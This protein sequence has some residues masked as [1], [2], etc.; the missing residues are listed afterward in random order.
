MHYN[1]RL[2][3]LDALININFVDF[4][5][6]SNCTFDYNFIPYVPGFP[7]LDQISS[8]QESGYVEPG[9]FHIVKPW[10]PCF[11]MAE[12]L[13]SEAET[14]GR[15]N[16][17]SSFLLIDGDWK[18]IIDI[19]HLQPPQEWPLKVNHHR[20]YLWGIV[21]PNVLLE[22][23]PDLITTIVNGVHGCWCDG[24]W[25]EAIWHAESVVVVHPESICT[26]GAPKALRYSGSINIL[27]SMRV[28]SACVCMYS[29]TGP[30][31][32]KGWKR[33]LEPL[34]LY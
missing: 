4:S 24:E 22:P 9:V 26:D 27:K 16:I 20:D 6:C 28:L 10:D 32:C 15:W 13:K 21:V 11:L 14:L 30:G 8:R 2:C 23:F 19:T 33:V 12:L 31:A 34:E 5:C 18:P 29:M 7:V 3:S 17:A 25:G 1:Q